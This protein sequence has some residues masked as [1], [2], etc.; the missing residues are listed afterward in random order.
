MDSLETKIWISL[1]EN[2]KI[3][4]RNFTSINCRALYCNIIKDITSS[5]D[6]LCLYYSSMPL[7]ISD[8]ATEVVFWDRKCRESSLASTICQYVGEL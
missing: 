4:K 6:I 3:V 5:F 2:N 1:V 7:K 8:G